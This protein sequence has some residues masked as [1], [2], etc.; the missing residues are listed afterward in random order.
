M[1]VLYVEDNEISQR[2]MKRAATKFGHQLFIASTC[3]EGY[4]LAHQTLDLILLDVHLPDENGL[5]LAE[6]LRAERI[7]TPIIAVTSDLITCNRE[8]ALAA[9]CTDFME[10]PI[11]TEQIGW[12]FARYTP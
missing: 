1:K 6:R 12:L 8:M 10:K 9:G 5:D 7:S 11:L 4:H 2:L 3:A